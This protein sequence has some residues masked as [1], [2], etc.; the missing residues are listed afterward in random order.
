MSSGA[1]HFGLVAEVISLHGPED[2]E[3]AACK[4]QHGLRVAF[5]LRALAVVVV[6]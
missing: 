6:S 2:V 5:A 4:A 1:R 3:S